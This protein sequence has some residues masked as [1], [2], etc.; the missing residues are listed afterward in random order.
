M[1]I[2]FWKHHV[3]PS[4]F[5]SNFQHGCCSE[6]IAVFGQ[7]SWWDPGDSYRRGFLGQ[8]HFIKAGV[9]KAVTYGSRINDWDLNIQTVL[10]IFYFFCCAI[11]LSKG[12]LPECHRSA[13]QQFVPG[14]SLLENVTSKYCLSSLTSLSAFWSWIAFCFF[15]TRPHRRTSCVAGPGS[16]SICPTSVFCWKMWQISLVVLPYGPCRHSGRG[17][18]LVLSIFG[19]ETFPF[20]DEEVS[21]RVA[22]QV[23][24]ENVPL[25]T[26]RVVG[27]FF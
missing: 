22:G 15:W 2:I 5:H 1:F 13:S 12:V 23:L 4:H 25:G 3:G 18:H 16:K 6:G 26:W 19:R 11:V 24:K 20:F 17:F 8:P 10:F 9:C 14:V 7:E 21:P 27:P